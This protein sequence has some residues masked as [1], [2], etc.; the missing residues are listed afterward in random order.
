MIILLATS[1]CGHPCLVA[2]LFFIQNIP[3]VRIRRKLTEDYSLY[4]FLFHHKVILES[5]IFLRHVYVPP[6]GIKDNTMNEFLPLRKK[7]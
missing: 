6:K 3:I 7:F 2:L 1:L 5:I 4:M